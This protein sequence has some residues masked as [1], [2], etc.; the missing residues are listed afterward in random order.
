MAKKVSKNYKAAK[1]LLEK[2]S[3][4]LEEAV[5]LLPE[6]SKVKFDA[7]IEVHV[8]TGLDPRHADQIF[9][10]YKFL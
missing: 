7:S 4:S 1:A 3:Y 2:E 6:T 5:K 9:E 8:N 10:T